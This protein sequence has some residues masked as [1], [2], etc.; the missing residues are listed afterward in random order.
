MKFGLFA[1]N[2]GTCADPAVAVE[3][4]RAAEAA[5]FESAWSGEH[6]VLPDPR[7]PGSPFPPDLPLLDT[8]VALTLIAAHTTT[9][10]IGSGI[11]V[12]PLRNPVVL[13]KELASLDVVSGGRLL[14]GFGIGYID[15]EFQAVGVPQ[16]ER[17]ARMD[18]YLRALRALW[19]MPRPHHEGQFCS[20]TG[21]DAH[22]RPLAAGGPPM[23]IGGEGPKAFARAVTMANGW[24][25]FDPD[26]L[27][28]C[29]AGLRRAADKYERPEDLGQ[30]EITVTPTGPLDRAAVEHY[31]EL[32]V[33]RLVV[34]P[35]PD[36]TPT[37]RHRPVPRDEILR[38][39]ERISSELI[40]H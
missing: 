7:P 22:P 1:I 40:D 2:Y 32:G 10:R 25:G 8:I 19:T 20:F 18:D 31:T 14:A 36:A 3:V 15:A 12:L 39:I 17:Q 37:G 11:I 4:A 5:G 21:I 24:Y 16:T 6:L 13:A 28:G 26:D 9:L 38:N 27:A 23:I 30:L 35:K 29:L 34:L 33:D